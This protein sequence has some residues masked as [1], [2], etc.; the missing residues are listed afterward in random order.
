MSFTTVKGKT[1]VWLR[2]ALL[3]WLTAGSGGRVFADT[4]MAAVD[5][6]PLQVGNRWEFLA[7]GFSSSALEVTGTALVNGVTTFVV[8][9]DLGEQIFFTNDAN[10][11]RRH[12]EYYP[13]DGFDVVFTPPLK[14]A[15]ASMVVG[16]SVS[17][18]GIATFTIFGIGSFP[19]SYTSTSRVE[20]LE[21]VTVP[22]STFQTLRARSTIR[23]YGALP[24]G[25]LDET[26]QQTD[27]LAKHIGPVKESQ[28]SSDGSELLELVSTNLDDDADGT[29]DVID[30][31]PSLS[32]PRQEDNDGD[33]AGDVCD[34][35]DD[36][37][38]VPDSSDAFPLDN[39]ETVD[40]DGDG[41]G[42]NADGDDDGDGLSDQDEAVWGSDPLVVDSD[43]D[44]VGDG[45]EVALGRRPTVNEAAVIGII[46]EILRMEP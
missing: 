5:Y 4:V 22:A 28:V 41:I 29:G 25:Y 35:D 33:G 2:L 10:G 32:N 26:L 40:T 6:F 39:T 43:G 16:G 19:L 13:F 34:A 15:H 11:I 23:I 1:G 44:G 38:G 12:R 18:N 7:N 31:C 46:N 45:D 3:V 17:S 24:G 42:N 9:D 37:D 20:A 14:Q 30:N 27:W 21:T 36:N 8:T